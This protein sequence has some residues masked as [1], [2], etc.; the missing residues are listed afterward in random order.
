MIYL[1]VT[2]PILILAWV[3]YSSR[4]ILLVLGR[5]ALRRRYDITFTGHEAIE[6]KFTYLIVPNH[7]AIVDPL[8]LATELHAMG[9][10]VRPLVDESFFSNHIVRHVLALFDAVRVPDFQKLNFRPIL[11][12]QPRK[13]D[14][15]RRAR[16]LGY[17]VLATL[18]AGG[19]V[20]LYP[21]GHISETGQEQIKNRQ[22]AHNVIAQLP[23]DIHVLGVRIRGLYGSRWSRVGGHPPPPFVK[24]FITSSFLWCI[25][26]FRKKR[27]VEIHFEDITLRC[28]AWATEGRIGFNRHLEQW[29]DSDLKLLGRVR[30][31]AS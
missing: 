26:G 12:I 25:A 19:N 6:K 28:R 10:N 13:R 30:E 16:A 14:S 23:N 1:F 21:S 7:P 20:L 15:L 8:L 18:T 3:F 22:L 5:W 9:I 27:Q 17:T 4:D 2:L 11:K 29:Y 31:E 24:T